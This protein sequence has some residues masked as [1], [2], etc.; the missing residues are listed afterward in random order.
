MATKV[1]A[2]E[3]VVVEVDATVLRKSKA[4]PVS[5]DAAIAKRTRELKAQAK[6]MASPV[7]GQ[8]E[9]TA[10]VAGL[11]ADYLEVHEGVKDERI[12]PARW[13][14]AES[15]DGAGGYLYE[16]RVWLG[17]G[18]DMAT[19]VWV[20]KM[21]ASSLVAGMESGTLPYRWASRHPVKGVKKFDRFVEAA[22]W[23]RTG[24][25]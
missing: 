17:E 15:A 19:A 24:E 5:L 9:R 22:T 23:A 12:A 10:E 21:M 20:Q 2:E 18:L 3:A 8:A 11:L 4:A 7:A 13:E 6:K 1:K 16:V 25:G 14:I